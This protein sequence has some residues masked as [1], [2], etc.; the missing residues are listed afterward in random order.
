M[1]FDEFLKANRLTIRG[2]ARS[3]RLPF[4]TVQ[5]AASGVSLGLDNARRVSDLTGGVVPVWRLMGLK[6]SDL[7]PLR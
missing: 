4:S 3:K 7:A 2:F 1:T 6:A 5:R